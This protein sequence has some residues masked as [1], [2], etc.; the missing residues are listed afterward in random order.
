MDPNERNKDDG[1]FK[2]WTS[3]VKNGGEKNNII[4]GI[5]VMEFKTTTLLPFQVFM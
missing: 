4:V 5:M 2:Q 1:R 3:S